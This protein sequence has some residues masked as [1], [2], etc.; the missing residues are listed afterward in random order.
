METK[1]IGKVG[2]TGLCPICGSPCEIVGHTT[3]G[4]LIGQC[5]SKYDGSE[6]IREAFTVDQWITDCEEDHT[7]GVY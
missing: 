2:E 3:D 6:P 4:R 7:N 1:L 5:R